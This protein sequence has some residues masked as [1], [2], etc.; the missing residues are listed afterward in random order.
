MT[1]KPFNGLSWDNPLNACT[2]DCIIRI[3]SCIK[4]YTPYTASSLL[5]VRWPC[6]NIQDIK[7]VLLPKQIF[8]NFSRNLGK[9]HVVKLQTWMIIAYRRS[10]I[11]IF[12][13]EL[14]ITICVTINNLSSCRE[15]WCEF[16]QLRNIDMQVVPHFTMEKQLLNLL[17]LLKM[18]KLCDMLKNPWITWELH[19]DFNHSKLGGLEVY[20]ESAWLTSR[21]WNPKES[22]LRSLR[23]SKL[24]HVFHP[25]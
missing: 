24:G 25:C 16:Q 17:L 7:L 14:W 18:Y 1:I 15:I 20:L 22:G 12:Y 11:F 13:C 3:L 19:Y 5:K 10:S 4:P 23:S 2:Y 21:W 6:S 8:H 9:L